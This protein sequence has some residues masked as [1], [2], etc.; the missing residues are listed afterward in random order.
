MFG[1]RR[2]ELTRVNHYFV[3][4]SRAFSSPS[5]RKF[6]LESPVAPDVSQITENRFF[7]RFIRIFLRNEAYNSILQTWLF[8]VLKVV[9]SPICFNE[10]TFYSVIYVLYTLSLSLSIFLLYFF[11]LLHSLQGE[12]ASGSEDA[13]TETH[14]AAIEFNE[15]RW[16][17][18]YNCYAT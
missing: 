10:T 5:E 8:R 15:W 12:I 6:S 17:L 3:A 11:L 16:F 9:V 7:S 1:G 14:E 2:W 18:R 4:S 13:L